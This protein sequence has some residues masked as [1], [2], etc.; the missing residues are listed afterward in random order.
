ML[1]TIQ[2][3]NSFRYRKKLLFDIDR[4][5]REEQLIKGMFRDKYLKAEMKLSCFFKIW[6]VICLRYSLALIY[7]WYGLL[8]VLGI[9]P[10]EALVQETTRWT[11]IHPFVVYLGIW[12]MAIGICMCSKKFCRFGLLLLFLQFPG[13][14]LPL[15]LSPEQCFTHFPYGLTFEG[16]YIFKNLILV[17]SGLVLIGNLRPLVKNGVSSE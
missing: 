10:V 5:K 1:S 14:F 15:F 11:Q 3:L 16:Q 13:T 7:F 12:E 17:A 4:N 9:S 2:F 6:G 8:K